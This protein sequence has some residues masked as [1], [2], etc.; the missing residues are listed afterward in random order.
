MHAVRAVAKDHKIISY[1]DDTWQAFRSTD[2][3]VV[4]GVE[5]W[6]DMYSDNNVKVSSGHPA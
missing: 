6:W 5:C 4:N 1:G 3:R 2:V